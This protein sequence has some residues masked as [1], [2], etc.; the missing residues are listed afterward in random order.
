MIL[1]FDRQAGFKK[2]APGNS[3]GKACVG[4]P[5]KSQVRSGLRRMV[6]VIYVCLAHYSGLGVC[7][8][9]TGAVVSLKDTSPSELSAFPAAM[10]TAKFVHEAL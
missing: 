10:A 9:T 2:R 3:I 7:G 1:G 5:L 6:R 8:K 4:R